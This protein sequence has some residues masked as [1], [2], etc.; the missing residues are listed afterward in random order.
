MP[1]IEAYTGHPLIDVG[2]ATLTAYAHKRHPRELTQ[3]DLQSAADYMARNYVVNPL[4][5]FLTVAFPN[6][7]F[8]NPAF[9]NS[10]DK[11]QRYAKNV[12]YAYTVAESTGDR[13]PFLD[14]PATAQSY[15]IKG[16][17][18]PGRAYRQHVPLVTGEGCI[19]FYP[20]GDPGLPLHGVTL[21]A[22]H[23][24]PLG[25]AKVA[26][27]LLAVHSDHPELLLYFAK[28][29][30]TANLKNIQTAQ[31]AGAKKLPETSPHRARTLL[32]DHLMDA[33]REQRRW[34]MLQEPPPTLTAYHFTN[35]G[36]G[37]DLSIYPL[38]LEVAGFLAAVQSPGYAEAWAA[39]V[40][41]GWQITHTKRGKKAPP[42]TYNRLYEDLFQLPE[43]AATFIRR[44]FLR[45][46]GGRLWDE[47]DPTQTYDT[48][49]DAAL[50]SWHLTQL[51][52][53]KVMLMD[54][55][56]IQHIQALGDDLANYIVAQNDRRFFRHFYMARRYDEVRAALIKASQAQ[57]RRG[58]PPLITLER[59]LAVFEQTGGIPATDWRLGR[60]LVLIRML[61]RLF[62]Q[63]WLQAH[64]EELSAAEE[65]TEEEEEETM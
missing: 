44:Y 52:L 8:T 1:L 62:E 2:L 53:R 46:P 23:A 38:P 28:I 58:Q 65:L 13:D 26:G 15:D 21:L 59:F 30:L 37:A 63:G 10:P 29:F 54:E 22:I 7:G 51:F 5:S 4:R 64:T 3:H 16:E 45:R 61:E 17:L 18:P 31:T 40:R 6:S 19:N 35:S 34:G 11:Q 32:I 9:F 39:L 50:I 12:L 20:Y 27:R 25:C 24:L 42:P 55:L 60:D 33:M 48:L 14:V 43:Q 41:R 36:R 56:R 57:I 47:K 49:R